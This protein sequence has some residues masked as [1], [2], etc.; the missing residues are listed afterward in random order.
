VKEDGRVVLIIGTSKDITEQKRAEIALRESESRLRLALEATGMGTWEWNRL[1]G[2]VIWDAALC[3][4]L[5][6]EPGAAPRDFAEYLALVHPDDSE[7][8]GPC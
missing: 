1:S 2:E 3:K 5:G 7:R 4:I 8:V 6:L